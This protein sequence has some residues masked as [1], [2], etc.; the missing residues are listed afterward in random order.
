M[1][2]PEIA[3]VLSSKPFWQTALAKHKFQNKT[4]IAP[5]DDYHINYLA[6]SIMLKQS[7]NED[8]ADYKQY[9]NMLD[10]EA[11][12]VVW[13][14]LEPR[15]MIPVH[16]DY[17]YTLKTKKNVETEDCIRYLIML[18]DWQLGHLVQFEDRTIDMWKSGDV[19]YFDSAE[20]HCAAN[21]GIN[22][23]YSCQVSTIKSCSFPGYI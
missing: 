8:V 4:P 12:S 14:C 19:W 20:K 23:F 6:P 15:E 22:N 1:S 2:S 9:Y 21:S 18:E 5:R 16:Q 11:G 17:F 3:W 13:L 10:V 7:F